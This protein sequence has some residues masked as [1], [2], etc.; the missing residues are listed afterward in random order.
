MR[1]SREIQGNQ[2][3]LPTEI[4]MWNV[5][6]S[7]KNSFN[8]FLHYLRSKLDVVV[9]H[10]DMG[11]LRIT[12]GCRSLQI[13]EE[14]W[15]DYR[16]GH[17]NQIAQDTLITAEIL[18]TLELTKLTLK[19]FISEEQYKKGKQIF[20]DNSGKSKGSTTLSACII[21]SLYDLFF[22]TSN[23]GRRRRNPYQNC[24]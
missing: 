17:L 20:M 8:L 2:Q 21:L 5:I 12:V 13:L 1:S 3:D 18:E 15:H 16:S 9:I 23:I 7:F 4:D 11:S 22:A 19:T 14:L 10:L 6:V 24:K